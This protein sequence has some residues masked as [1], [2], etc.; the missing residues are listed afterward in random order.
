MAVTVAPVPPSSLQRLHRHCVMRKYLH[1][2]DVWFGIWLDPYTLRVR[3]AVTVQYS[4]Q[5]NDEMERQAKA[6]VKSK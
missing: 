6:F 3:T 4:W 5:G 1:K 2:A